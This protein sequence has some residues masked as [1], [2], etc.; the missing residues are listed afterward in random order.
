[1]GR[2]TSD[3]VLSVAT[4]FLLIGGGCETRPQSAA[5]AMTQAGEALRRGDP[6][7]AIRCYSEVIR[8]KPDFALAYY[9]R[10]IAYYMKGDLD[11]AI[12]D[13]TAAIRLKP[14]FD[15][16]YYS[17][18][19]A[20]SDKGDFDRAIVDYTEAIR[21]MSEKAPV[22]L[23]YHARGTAYA[24]KGE[25]ARADEDFARAKELGSPAQD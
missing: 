5:D 2:T 21:L 20:Y 6:D 22:Y 23:V 3:A 11:R 7:G 24:K 9:S 10:G 14:D 15:L 17:R 19:N 13:Q 8:L 4:L 18:G 16:A 1:M 25:K 12:T